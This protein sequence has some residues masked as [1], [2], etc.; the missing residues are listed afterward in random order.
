MNKS[1]S[2]YFNTAAKMDRAFIELLAE[3]DFEYITVKEI[4]RRAGVNRSTFYLHYENIADLL[5]ESVDYAIKDISGRFHENDFV[6]KIK[7]RPLDELFLITPQYL[8]PYLSY[9]RDN[10]KLF[11][12]MVKQSKTLGLEKNYRKLFE[13]VLNP[14]LER[15]HVPSRRRKY[16]TTFYINGIIA[17]V[18]DWLENDCLDSIEEVSGIIEFVVNSGAFQVKSDNLI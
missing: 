2:K 1:D 4:C 14:I 9:V 16:I 17:I 10:K 12:T 3:K 8:I 5:E 11:Q 7:G 18:M 6:S 15:F 13:F